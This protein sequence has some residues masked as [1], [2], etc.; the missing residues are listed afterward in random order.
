MGTFVQLL[1]SGLV[2]GA[3]YSLIALGIVLI[4]KSSGVFNFAQ[5]EL[6]ILGGFFF[7]TLAVQ[8]GLPVWLSFVL[9]LLIS[10]VL[11][12]ILER[13][14]LRPMV[15]QSVFAAIL[16]TIT[17]SL[18]L[19]AAALSAWPHLVYSYQLFPTEDVLELGIVSITMETVLSLLITLIVIGALSY[20]FYFARG[21]LAMRAVAEDHQVAQSTGISPT[22]IFSIAWASAAAVAAVGGI[23]LGSQL[24]LNVNLA[25]FGL[26][27]VAV[28][29]LGGLESL[30]GCMVAG[31]IV[32]LAESMAV[33]YLDPLV[34]DW[35]P[36]AAAGGGIRE[37]FPYIILLIVVII[38]PY[39]L[40]GL[41]K[42]ER[43]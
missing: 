3:I 40:F 15:G 35:S 14:A 30:L 4:F 1:V 9:T 7:W 31:V 34:M 17:L 26:T 12:L 24:G 28:V 37:V 36:A 41:R 43:V 23:F 25:S 20:Y 13:I 22:S 5:G 8:I 42:I 21:G 27:A 38:R 39:G 29:L 33:G 11:G 16:M 32:G 10:A 19:K 18:I 6:L 2:V